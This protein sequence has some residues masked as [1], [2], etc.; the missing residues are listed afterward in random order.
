VYSTHQPGSGLREC[1]CA[2]KDCCRPGWNHHL[3]LYRGSRS[4][5]INCRP[6]P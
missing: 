3:V 4:R 2:G 6:V 1:S 5:T